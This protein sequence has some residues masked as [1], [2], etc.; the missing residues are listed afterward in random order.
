MMT[1][2]GMGYLMMVVTIVTVQMMD[3]VL[4]ITVMV[5]LKVGPCT[6]PYNEK[7]MLSNN[8]I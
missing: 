4:T 5:K 2:N 3:Y 6:C 1:P 8:T 7:L